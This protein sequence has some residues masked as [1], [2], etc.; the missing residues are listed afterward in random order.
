[1]PHNSL[2]A[3]AS[4][5]ASRVFSARDRAALEVL[6]E[7]TKLLEGLDR[8]TVNS[9]DAATIARAYKLLYDV[10][11]MVP[12]IECW[13]VRKHYDYDDSPGWE[14]CDISGH[15]TRRLAEAWLGYWRERDDRYTIQIG[16]VGIGDYYA[17]KKPPQRA[18]W[19]GAS[20]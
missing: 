10:H 20:L 3:T 17:G 4:V 12:L 16:S 2:R 15:K 19:E 18:T 1:M 5:D 6:R 11:D 9:G 14:P 7:A 13:T 8:V